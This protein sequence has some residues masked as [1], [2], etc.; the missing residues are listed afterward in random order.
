MLDFSIAAEAQLT[1]GG[2]DA[3]APPQA[4]PCAWQGCGSALRWDEP[5][6]AAAAACLDTSKPKVRCVESLPLRGEALASI[7]GSFGAV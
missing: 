5:H 3:R 7:W 2:G 6:A 4:A 1:G